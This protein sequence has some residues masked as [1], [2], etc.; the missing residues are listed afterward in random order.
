MINARNVN[1]TK[2]WLVLGLH[3]HG[4]V[5]RFPEVESSFPGRSG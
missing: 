2:P 4:I 1:S 3:D 5:V